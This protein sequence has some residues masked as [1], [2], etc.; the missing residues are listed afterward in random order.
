MNF[1]DMTKNISAISK[2]NTETSVDIPKQEFSRE[3]KDLDEKVR[4]LMVLGENRILTNKNIDKQQKAHICQVCGKEGQMMQ[5]RDHIEAQH[6]EGISIPCN[7][8]SKYFRTR[9]ALRQ[10][11]KTVLTCNEKTRT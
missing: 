4:M 7:I 10:H 1:Q 6:I 8:C 3:L 2:V 5:I 11:K 9:S